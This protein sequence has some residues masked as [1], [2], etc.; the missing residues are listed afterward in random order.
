MF[1]SDA[2]GVNEKGRLTI[3]G[4]DTVE[5]AAQFGTPLY[6]MDQNYIEK[7]MREYKSA[8]DTYYG[9]RGMI[10]YASKAFCAKEICRIAHKEGLGLDVVSGGELYTA[11][12][13]GVP[14]EKLC[15]HGNN[16]SENEIG[17]AVREGVGRI[18]ADN[19][20]ELDII[21]KEAK[22]FGRRQKVLIRI[23]PGIEAHTHEFISTGRID[24]K[25]GIALKD[26]VGVFNAAKSYEMIEFAG[27]HCHIGSQIFETNPFIE[28]AKV[29]IKLMADVKKETGIELYELDLGGGFGIKYTDED[30]PRAY[31]E[32]VK[33]TIEAVLSASGEYGINPPFL[34][35][36]PGRSI[37][38]GA[39]ITL[40]TVGAIKDIKGVRKYVSVDGGMADNPRFI[41]YGARYDA[42][43]AERPLEK[44]VEKVTI[45]GKSCESGD[46]LIRDILMPEIKRGELLAVLSTGAYNYS[47]SSNY[48]RLPRPAVVMIKDGEPRIIVKRETYE[49]LTRNDL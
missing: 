15:L 42:L 26:V 19:K 10:F 6:I 27:F 33:D 11:I 20:E 47:M 44:K 37:V 18:V 45:S 24:S 17:M 43:L 1:V 9:G 13:A 14:A 32:Y 39:G 48:N 25:F 22:A 28:A 7:N 41:M 46:L 29:L 4:A 5:L 16:K 38:G 36:E 2:L 49:D 3:G 8:I 35:M 30:K 12:S 23:N 40:Y 34:I 21:E 31:T